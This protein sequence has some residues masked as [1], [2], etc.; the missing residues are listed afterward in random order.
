MLVSCAQRDGLRLICVTISDPNDWAD[1]CRAY[2]EA[3]ESWQYLPLPDGNWET[4]PVLSGVAEQTRLCCESDGLLLPKSADVQVE[5]A[6][7]RFVFAP[8]MTGETLGTLTVRLDGSPVLEADILCRDTVARD[9]SVRLT[10]KE[11]FQ[12]G[13]AMYCKYGLYTI[14]PM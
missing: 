10:V 2:D 5:V 3:Y 13:W 11:Q 12:R 14:Y 7:P 4:L 6:L 9:K 8:V 1:H